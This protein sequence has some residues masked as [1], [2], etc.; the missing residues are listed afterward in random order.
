MIKRRP[1][2]THLSWTLRHA[3]RREPHTQSCRLCPTR[4]P[5]DGVSGLRSGPL[6]APH[7]LAR[8][9]HH[10][11]TPDGLAALFTDVS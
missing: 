10:K 2:G 9:L 11:G 8:G 7:T 6:S 5:C 1:A 3:H 4:A